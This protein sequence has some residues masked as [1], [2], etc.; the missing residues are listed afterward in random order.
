MQEVYDFLKE[1]GTYYLATSE[2]GQPRVRPFG[3]IDIFDGRLTIQT[4]KSKSVSKQMLANPKVEICACAGD[5]WLRV[6]GEAVDEP[7]IE[8]QEHMLEAYPSLKGMYQAGDGNT[9]IFAIVNGE[10]TFS[11]F[12]SAPKVV[13]F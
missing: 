6:A 8:A 12:S 10:A 4:G 3:T 7:R 11:S 5:K 2:D 13:K 1:C 9:Q